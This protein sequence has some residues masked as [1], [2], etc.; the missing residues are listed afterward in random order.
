MSE[1][2]SLP[3]ALSRKGALAAVFVIGDNEPIR[4][5]DIVA[6][7]D[8]TGPT[9]STRLSDLQEADLIDRTLYDEMP[10]RTE[11]SLT[12]A[13]DELYEVVAPLFEWAE[14][15][16]EADS[17]PQSESAPEVGPELGPEPAPDADESSVVEP[18]QARSVP[19]PGAISTGSL[20]STSPPSRVDHSGCVPAGTP[21]GDDGVLSAGTI[22]PAAF[23][24]TIPSPS[25]PDP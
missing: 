4:F 22:P 19:P 5:R 15:Q 23:E 21:T 6:S 2:T 1:S 7:L 9:V 10:P 20:S 8:A 13:G 24:G 17:E 12:E 14:R 11:Y 3:D 25:D 18:D 16:S